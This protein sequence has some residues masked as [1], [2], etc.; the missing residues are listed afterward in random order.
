MALE[1]RQQLKLAQQLVM[2]P[3]LQQAIKLLQL[4]RLELAAT[5]QEELDQNPLLEDIGLSADQENGDAREREAGAEDFQ[6]DQE[7][8]QVTTEVR[9]DTNSSLQEINWQ[10]YANEYEPLPS[11]KPS[12]ESDL[13]SRLD[14]LTSKPDLQS[15]LQWQLNLTAVGD[16][17]VEVGEYIIGNLNRDGF[18]EVDLETIMQETGCDHDT[19][20]YMVELIQDM[21]PAGIAARSI[22]ESLLLQLERLDLDK[23]L[24]ATI[25][26]D[27]LSLMETRNYAGIVKATGRSK[28]SVQEAIDVIVSLDPFPGR[29]YSDEEPQYITPDVY[30]HKVDGEYVIMLNDD[31]LPRL[32][33]SNFY[34]DILKGDKA[35]GGST[36]EYISDKMKSAAWLIKSIQQ[37]Q[38]TIYKVVESIIKFQKD[39]FE[40]G[41]EHLKP[42][43]L[44]DVAEDI[45]MHESTISRVTNNKY[46]HTP[47]GTFELKYFF[48]SSIER[49]DG[50]DAMSSLSIK[51][52]IKAIVQEENSA[53]PLSDNAIAEIFEKDNIKLARRTVAKYREQLG[54]LPSKLR[55][56]P[57][58]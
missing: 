17:E 48:T 8:T 50:G 33:I 57:R 54:I 41:V 55:K 30:V 15:H 42:L 47:Q 23:S 14:I 26:R 53:K 10:D 18:L 5:I 1:L 40:R 44:R 19:A 9:M 45:E 58:F 35:A 31:G 13:P 20:E 4:S 25:V 16:E 38:R 43:V 39:F 24:A 6:S 37:R 51:N 12:E 32:R 56:S 34:R 22:Q 27:H 49:R 36:R 7:F 28:Q 21:D 29:Q 11:F 52:R 2:T 46:V 3:Q